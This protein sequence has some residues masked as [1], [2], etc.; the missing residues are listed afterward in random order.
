MLFLGFT[1]TIF[2]QV[3]STNSELQ[4]AINNAQAGSVITLVNQ[5]W[6]DVEVNINK[7]GTATNPIVITAQTPG[8]VFIEGN[9]HIE[10]RGNHIVLTGLVFQNASGLP[11]SSTIPPVIRLNA[12]DDCIVTNNKIDAFNGT[13]LQSENT[14][15]WILIDGKRNEISYNSFLGKNGVGSII[16]DNR[17]SVGEDYTK[18]HHNYFANRVPVG[19][20]VNDFNDQDAIR[21]GNSATSLSDS[22]TEVY[23]NYFHNFFGEVEIISNKSGS[24]KYYNNTFRNYAGS[25]TL[26]HGNNCEVYGNF[27]FAENNTFSAGIRVIG[28]GH[29]IYNNYIEAVN[30]LKEDGS[31]SNATGGINITNGR[32]NTEINGYYQVKDAI[33]TNNTFVNCDYTMRVGTKVKSD[34]SLAPSNVQISNNIFLNTSD[35]AYQ[36]VTTPINGSIAQANITQNGSWD[37]NNGSNQNSTVNSGLLVS[38]SNFYTIPSGSVAINYGMGSFPFLT[39]DILGGSR[40]NFDAGAEE[41]GANGTRSPFQANDVGLTIGFGAQPYGDSV[42]ILST[43]VN[44]LSFSKNSSTNVFNIS[45]NVNWNIA[46][47]G[48]SWV[49]TNPVSGTGNTSISVSALENTT[50]VDRM[51]EITISQVG[52]TLTKIVSITQSAIDFDPNNATEIIPVSVVGE[53]TQD[54]NTPEN[55]LDDNDTTR[56]SGDSGSSEANLTFDLGCEQLATGV[57]IKFFKGDERTS[58]FKILTSIDNISFNDAT[59]ILTSSGTT[60]N[61]EQF[62]F[63][64]PFLEA[65]YFRIQGLGNSGSAPNNVFNSYLEVE[66]IGNPIDC[67]VLSVEDN[68]KEIDFISV[69]PI[70]VSKGKLII[71][72]SKVFINTIDIY[73]ITGKLLNKYNYKMS[74]NSLEL[75]VNNLNTGMYFLKINDT[76]T[77][78]II[79]D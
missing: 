35:N 38:G 50:G 46:I 20:T 43:S 17:N 10:L 68:N 5:I 71:K 54:P 6:N 22:F 4:I 31:V 47:S 37:L 65:Q 26:R 58:S 45:A 70:P 66:I 14:F 15:K 8:S 32:E 21:I 34:L 2:S 63:S 56:W 42:E 77:Q 52:G 53:G 79:I 74:D 23:E 48:G 33:I 76:I 25:L 62:D 39:N 75:D 36:E 57:R 7:N 18:I 55:V 27:F 51:A 72:S 73:S 69:Y 60:T 61:Y 16:N 11:N 44:T 29:K 41:F 40:S 3:V 12:C 67:D 64:S 1:G 9:S 24:N 19:G 13:N 78:K 28:E 59:G 49:S 30:S